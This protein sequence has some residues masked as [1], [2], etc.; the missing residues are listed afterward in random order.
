M[1]LYLL[2]VSSQGIQAVLC[3]SLVEL[4]CMILRMHPLVPNWH[5]LKVDRNL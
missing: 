4:V 1:E 3:L 2:Q 5:Q